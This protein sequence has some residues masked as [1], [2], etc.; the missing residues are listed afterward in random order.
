MKTRSLLA[1]GV[2]SLTLGG[3]V[4]LPAASALPA[5][6]GP[7]AKEQRAAAAAP[8]LSSAKAKAERAA[9]AMPNQSSARAKAERAAAAS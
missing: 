2:A 8:N 3:A 1:L 7:S 4:A 9:A 6:P 5:T